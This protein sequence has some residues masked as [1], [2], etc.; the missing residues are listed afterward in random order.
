MLGLH[1]I[2]SVLTCG[3]CPLPKYISH[4][5]CCSQCTTLTESLF[6]FVPQENLT[7]KHDWLFDNREHIEIQNPMIKLELFYTLYSKSE[8]MLVYLDKN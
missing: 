6:Y 3:M 2:Q 8:I 1:S 5:I 7:A 4:L